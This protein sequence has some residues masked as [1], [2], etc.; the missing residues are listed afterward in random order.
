MGR[1]KAAVLPVPVCAAARTSRPARTS[2]MAASW[3]GV[4]SYTPPRR[5]CARD[6][7][8]GR[9]NRRSSV[10]LLQ[11]SRRGTR[12]ERDGG[13]A[14]C[15]DGRGRTVGRREHSGN[16]R[17]R[18][19]AAADGRARGS[20]RAHGSVRQRSTKSTPIS[21][22]STS[23]LQRVATAGILWTLPGMHRRQ[24]QTE[25][26]R[27]PTAGN[28][29]TRQAPTW[30][31]RTDIPVPPPASA[32]CRAPSDDDLARRHVPCR[33]RHNP[34]SPCAHHAVFRR[35]GGKSLAVPEERRPEGVIQAV[36]PSH[37]HRPRNGVGRSDRGQPHPRGGGRDEGRDRR[38]TG[39]L[40]H[41]QLQ[42][43]R[44]ALRRPGPLV[45]RQRR[46]DLQP[47]R[48]M[49]AG[50]G[51][52]PGREGPH[53]PRPRQ[54]LPQS[55]RCLLEIHQGRLR[56]Q[57]DGLERELQHQVLGRVLHPHPDRSRPQRGRHPEPLV[58]RLGQLRVGL[59]QP[60][61]VGGQAARPELRLW[62]PAR[63]CAGSLRRGITNAS[64][65]LY[66]LFKTNRSIGTI[67]KSS[68]NW[69]GSYDFQFQSTRNPD[70]RA[71]MDPKSPGRYYRSVVGNFSLT[72]NAVR[73]S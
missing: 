28:S 17:D 36:D 47:E 59:G 29:V 65:I 18:A 24:G 27:P 7:P 68:S 31:S 13:P 10:L 37:R 67:F 61:Q 4:G 15:V 60:D 42:G 45:R 8:T 71:W 22:W 49:V 73:I 62:V 55:V 16:G 46:R 34:P 54:R 58:L 20:I 25:E 26:R 39:R 5:P 69:S 44:E 38:R 1:T 63:R 30:H 33:R 70:Y 41:S 6:R 32:R 23:R 11:W 56:A 40:E 66:G 43:Q 64:Y 72:A 53:L 51:G 48:D 19:V 3:T 2:G 52:G 21:H 9:V 12:W 57:P 14:P 35:R 50:Q